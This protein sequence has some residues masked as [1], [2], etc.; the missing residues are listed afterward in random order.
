MRKI[1]GERELKREKVLI[2]KS[3]FVSQ[4]NTNV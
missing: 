3:F 1:K 4:K 2:I